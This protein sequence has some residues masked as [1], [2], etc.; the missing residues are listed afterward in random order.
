MTKSMQ[1]KNMLDCVQVN[2]RNV[3]QPNE[4]KHEVVRYFNCLFSE[5]WEHRPMIVGTLKSLNSV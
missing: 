1:S 3:M 5:N 4:V 2:G